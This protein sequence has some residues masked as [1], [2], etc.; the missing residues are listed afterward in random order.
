[1]EDLAAIRPN[2]GNIFTLPMRKATIT[3]MSS[4][5][6]SPLQSS[7]TI[8]TSTTATTISSISKKEKAE[9]LALRARQ[10]DSDN[11]ILRLTDQLK[12]TRNQMSQ[13]TEQ[14]VLDRTERDFFRLK[15]A[16]KEPEAAL[17]FDRYS[18]KT[19]DVL[20]TSG[21]VS[22]NAT[23]TSMQGYIRE[24]EALK[25]A[26]ADTRRQVSLQTSVRGNGG[27]KQELE[28]MEGAAAD[29]EELDFDSAEALLEVELTTSVAR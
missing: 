26:L 27:Q 5:I 25:L 16:E 23:M 2:D 4:R 19:I 6:P 29:N 20:D 7:Q 28:S 1:M 13:L 12:R 15:W 3:D 14:A 17:A 22:T 9:L 10:Q 24:I 18:S 11:E 21:N 8:S